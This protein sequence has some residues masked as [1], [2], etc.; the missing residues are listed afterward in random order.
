MRKSLLTYFG[1]LLGMLLLTSSTQAQELEW[2]SFEDALAIAEE[3][4]RPIVVD[5]WAP[6]C[7]WCHKMQKETYPAL[8]KELTQQFVFTRLNRDDHETEYQYQGQKLISMRLA[9]KLNAQTVPTIIV[10]SANGNYRF[11]LSGF[12]TSEK[13]RSVLL[14]TQQ[15]TSR[16]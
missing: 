10:L 7:G 16:R 5:V 15:F 1:F 2:H 9:Q 4:E 11:H 6:W 12:L 13:L 3:T 14:Q 8:S